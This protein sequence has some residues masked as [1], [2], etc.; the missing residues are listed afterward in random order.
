MKNFTHNMVDFEIEAK[1]NS[2][3]NGSYESKFAIAI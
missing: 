3:T 2:E 1:F